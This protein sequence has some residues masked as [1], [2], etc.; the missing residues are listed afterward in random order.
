MYENKQSG[1]VS[2]P[3]QQVIV[4]YHGN[5][6]NLSIKSSHAYQRVRQRSSNIH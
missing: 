2:V 5:N 6:V 1:N 4:H 3:W